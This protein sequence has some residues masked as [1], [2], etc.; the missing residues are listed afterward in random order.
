MLD[1]CQ[2][3]QC[4]SFEFNRDNV[5]CQGACIVGQL[6]KTFFNYFVRFQKKNTLVIYNNSHENILHKLMESVYF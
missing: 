4:F 2:F 5:H 6:T 3:I 1:F